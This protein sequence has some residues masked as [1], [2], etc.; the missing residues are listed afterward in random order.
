MAQLGYPPVL[1][2]IIEEHFEELD[3][4]WEQ[5]EGVIFAPDWNLEELA[6]LEERAEAHLDGLRLAEGHAVDIARPALSGEETF[7]ATA[8]TFVF[9]ETGVEELAQEVLEAFK[10]AEAPETRDGIR[11][12]LRHSKIDPIRD[13]LLELAAAEDEALAAAAADLLTFQRVEVPDL[14]RLRAAEEPA[15]RVLVYGALGRARRFKRPEDLKAALGDDD[16]EV[17]R[18]ALRAA[19]MSGMPGLEDLCRDAAMDGEAPSLEALGFLGIFGN[20]VDLP[21]LEA[22][23]GDGEC[24]SVAI[25]ALGA[26][27]RVQTIPLLIELMEQDEEHARAAAE[28]FQRITGEDGIEREKPPPEPIDETDL[29]GEFE[30]DTPPPDPEKAKAWWEANHER[31]APEGRWQAG[32]EVSEA[33]SAPLFNDLPL[34]TRRD[35]HLAARAQGEGAVAD[36]EL[37][38]RASG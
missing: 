31:F 12:G 29:E 1:I 21:L 35:L 19:A 11:I 34:Q 26:L 38:G 7:A 24:A 32:I 23:A 2:D 13:D 30:D 16:P 37:E 9:M 15:V 17:Q 4:L 8:A 5:R 22:A 36:R 14:E 28:A 6:E 20:P 18:A 33:V 25:A 3:F 27:G 10:G